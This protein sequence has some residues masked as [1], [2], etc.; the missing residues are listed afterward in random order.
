M[1]TLDSRHVRLTNRLES[2]AEEA[3]PYGQLKAAISDVHPPTAEH[4]IRVRI[5]AMSIGRTWGLSGKDLTTLA[6]ASEVHD[7]GKLYVPA[8]ILGKPGP[9]SDEEWEIIRLHP[10]WGVEI[11]QGV[12]Q[13]HQDVLDC[14]LHHH[15]R[16]DGSGYPDR[17]H[18]HS[19]PPLC[20][21]L[22]VA[23]AYASLTEDRPYRPAF[24]AEDAMVV[25]K[26]VEHGKYDN[27]VMGALACSEELEPYS[28]SPRARKR[29]PR[30][31]NL[32]VGLDKWMR[33][34]LVK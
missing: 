4:S 2:H 31:P 14:I 15:E 24:S 16:L 3:T 8:A 26:H 32:G 1:E 7:A 25:L 18:G 27:D 22:S 29:L 28:P 23:D 10:A 34:E 9:L 30:L 17:L 19:I 11:V 6:L 33:G 20:R 21:M 13:C 12:F 5:L